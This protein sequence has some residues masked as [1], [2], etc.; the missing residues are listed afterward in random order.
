M[1]S[2]EALENVKTAPSFMGGN[3][4]YWTYLNSQ[5]PFLEDIETIK[6]DLDRLE[7]LE[8]ENQE[9]VVNKNVAQGIAIKLKE[10]NDRLKKALEILK[11]KFKF[12]LGVSVVK[13][14]YY[15]SLEFL[16]NNQYFTISQEEYKLLKEVLDND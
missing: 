7:Q 4:K 14:K 2:K 11:D 3:P 8:K 13:E 9:L 5:F 15:Y 1:K 12:E 10:E 6:Q 16:Y